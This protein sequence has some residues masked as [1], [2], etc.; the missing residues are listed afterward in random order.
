MAA[1]YGATAKFT[2]GS[3][4]VNVAI[5]NDPAGA[6]PTLPNLQGSSST[7]DGYVTATLSA[8]DADGNRRIIVT[9]THYPYSFLMMPSDQ[10]FRTVTDTEPYE[11]S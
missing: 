9:I 11:G 7:S 6:A 1:R 5:Y 8:P 2:D 3:A 4:I 10:D